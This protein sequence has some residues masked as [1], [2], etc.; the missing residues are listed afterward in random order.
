MGLQEQYPSFP[1]LQRYSSFCIN[2]SS[3]NWPDK[4]LFT[5]F[6]MCWHLCVHLFTLQCLLI[7][8]LT[9][10]RIRSKTNNRIGLFRI[11]KGRESTSKYYLRLKINVIIE[12]PGDSYYEKNVAKWQCQFNCYLQSFL[13]LFICVS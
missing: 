10:S 5:K 9:R 4:W 3:Q 2:S 8:Y 6:F 7:E 1:F 11:I 13:C 12:K